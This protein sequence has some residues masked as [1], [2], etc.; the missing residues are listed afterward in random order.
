MDQKLEEAIKKSGNNLHIKVANFFINQGWKTKLSTYYI[1][2]TTNKPREIDIMA[3]KIFPIPDDTRA[4][5]LRVNLLIECKHFNE[6]IALWMYDRITDFTVLNSHDINPILL[7]QNGVAEKHHYLNQQQLGWLY[8]MGKNTKDNQE[9]MFNAI[10]QPVKSLTF[11]RDKYPMGKALHY[12][13]CVYEGIPGIYKIK[14]L[15]DTNN[16]QQLQPEP[17][18][19]VGLNYSY[20]S[21]V[22]GNL[23]TG[24][25]CVDFVHF[26]K[27]LDYLKLITSECVG[28]KDILAFEKRK[29]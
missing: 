26:D 17:F 18:V 19:T 14:S 27:L 22:N 28:I 5:E 7:Q 15:A 13:I 20:K 1:D 8:D 29:R 2:D 24:P 23:Q 3:Q 10:I 4:E 9:F 12:A 6:E 16:L 21:S 11:F 25:Y